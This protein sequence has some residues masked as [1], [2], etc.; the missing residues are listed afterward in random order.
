MRP[1][2]SARGRV[3]VSCGQFRIEKQREKECPASFREA[4]SGVF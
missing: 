2:P 1:C 4:N 3:G